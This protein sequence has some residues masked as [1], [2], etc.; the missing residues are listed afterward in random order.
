MSI[1][2]RHRVAELE[3]GFIACACGWAAEEADYGRA[4]LAHCQHVIR[5]A[6][7]HDPD[8]PEPAGDR[9][10]EPAFA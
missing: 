6:Q 2:A 1:A 8:R 3:G 10:P 7:G 9:A 4:Y 5:V